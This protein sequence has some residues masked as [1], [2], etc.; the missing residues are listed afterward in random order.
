[1][2]T[3]ILAIFFMLLTFN[4]IAEKANTS[5]ILHIN[6]RDS[7]GTPDKNGNTDAYVFSFYSYARTAKAY[8][9]PSITKFFS[10]E[11]E[12]IFNPLFSVEGRDGDEIN[13]ITLNIDNTIFNLLSSYAS[14]IN[15][16][17]KIF[18]FKLTPE[19]LNAI[20]KANFVAFT[21]NYVRI[22]SSIDY[23]SPTFFIKDL[24]NFKTNLY[25]LKLTN[26]SPKIAKNP[27]KTIKSYDP[28]NNTGNFNDSVAEVN[29]DI[30][31]EINA[32]AT[33]E[34]NLTNNSQTKEGYY[35]YSRALPSLKVKED[36]P[37]SYHVAK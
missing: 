5:D 18:F 10:F 16:E 17:S 8:L 26:N 31:N 2:K 22:D 6:L 23:L 12:K 13:S 34:S 19:V 20:D 11:D 27:N 30:A 15:S 14:I 28:I 35:S 9:T 1:M 7:L 3:N 32:G 36:Y 21:V 4:V 29:S 33:S 37:P 24:P 25:N